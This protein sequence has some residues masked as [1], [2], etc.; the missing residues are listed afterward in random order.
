[1]SAVSQVIN[2]NIGSLNAQRNLNASQGDL[3]TS[4]QRLSSG[5]RINSA[6]DDAAGLA[7]TERFSAQIRGL[8]QAVRNANDGVSLAQTGEGALAQ[9]VSG[10]QRIRE[11]AVQAAN[12]TNSAS[13]RASMQGEV[14]Q[15]VAEIQRIAST[16][17]FNGQNILDGSF[18][19]AKFQVGA[20][21]GQTIDV[22]IGNASATSIGGHRGYAFVGTPS[23]GSDASAGNGVASQN[24]TIAGHRGTASIAIDA[25]AS[26]KAI[27][28]AISAVES[29]TGVA[30]DGF[31]QMSLSSFNA[32]AV[33]QVSFDLTS[34]DDVTVQVVANVASA[35]DLTSLADA[36]N[37]HTATT[38]VRAELN[39]DRA[40]MELFAEGGENITLESVRGGGGDGTA[41]FSLNAETLVDDENDDGGNDSFVGGQL[42]RFISSQSFTASSDDGGDTLGLGGTLSSFL[43]S[44][45]EISVADTLSASF[46]IAEIDSALEYVN[47]MRADLGALQT[48]FESTINNLSTTA[49]NL[50]A[51]RSRIRDA[52]FAAETAALTRAQILQQAGTSVL[53]QANQTP[54]SVLALLQ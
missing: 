36:I 49:E 41:V 42:V 35:D 23:V 18:N 48:R 26:A 11:L 27:A 4:L 53:A 8:N 39:A 21:A 31:L 54:Q 47:G 51:A 29:Q 12:A 9:T 5:L 37:S 38:G 46:G 10:L 22:S 28:A 24:L 34:A 6:K 1:M 40:G 32:A 17:Q 33:G 44:I 52:D 50:S 45:A 3:Q 2:T 20:N 15:L 19:A 25:G 14:D 7:I 16:T 13:D 43:N 30:A